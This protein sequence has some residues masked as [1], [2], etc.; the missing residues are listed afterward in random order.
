[1]RLAG[2]ESV[3]VRPNPDTYFALLY[4]TLLPALFSLSF[5]ALRPTTNV[6]IGIG[7]IIIVI[8][9]IVIGISVNGI[10]FYRYISILVYQCRDYITQTRDWDGKEKKPSENRGEAPRRGGGGRERQGFPFFIFF[11]FSFEGERERG[12][13]GR[14]RMTD[15]YRVTNPNPNPI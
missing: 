7:F 14:W 8:I 10:K 15:D 9:V 5:P 6:G 3:R 1:M 12:K 13:K 2:R 11:F 4:F